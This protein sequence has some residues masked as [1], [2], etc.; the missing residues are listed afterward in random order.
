MRAIDFTNI[1]DK[2]KG[3]WIALIDDTQV[4]AADKDIKRVY[5]EAGKKGFPKARLFKVPQDNMP[6]VGLH[7]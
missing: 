3:L 1:F 2:Y 7:L 4:I 5:E 6:F